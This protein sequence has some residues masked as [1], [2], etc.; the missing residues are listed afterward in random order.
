M[1]FYPIKKEQEINFKG[2]GV[3]THD[4][5]STHARGYT[6]FMGQGKGSGRGMGDGAE[7]YIILLFVE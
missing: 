3:G 7:N 6:G 1:F 4:Q 2:G 5:K